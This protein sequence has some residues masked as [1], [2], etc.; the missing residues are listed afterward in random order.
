MPPRDFCCVDRRVP[1][2]R[3]R[4]GATAKARPKR[5]SLASP[6]RAMKRRRTIGRAVVNSSLVK[7]ALYGEDPNWGRVIAAAG[8]AR[9][10]LNPRPWF[11][12]AVSSG[13]NAARS[14]RF[15]KPKRTRCSRERPSRSRSTSA[16]AAA[17][18]TA[19]GCDFSTDY[20]RINAITGRDIMSTLPVTSLGRAD[21]YPAR[22]LCELRAP[23]SQLRARRGRLSVR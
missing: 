16:S 12:S 3:D 13:S 23:G 9:V 4:D 8:A 6:V 18:A 14:R 20:V 22:T 17:T 10:G 11:C 5:W 19:Y 7:T 15:P 1:R 21:R 2:S